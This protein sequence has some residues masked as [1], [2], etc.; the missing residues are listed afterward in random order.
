MKQLISPTI[1]ATSINMYKKKLELLNFSKVI[2]LDICDGHFVKTKTIN[3]KNCSDFDFL[4][5]DV[6]VHLMVEK[7]LDYLDDCVRLGVFK[8]FIHREIFFEIDDFIEVKNSFEKQGIEVALVLNPE[9]QV[10]NALPFIGQI[11]CVMLMSVI[12]GAEGQIFMEHVLEK[13]RQIRVLKENILIQ[14]DGGINLETGALSLERGVDILSVGSFIS[15]SKN[16]EKHYSLLQLIN[17][18]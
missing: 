10:E 16:P 12:P 6:E 14:I 18:H 8:V 5:H 4:D 17:N 7:P 15:S 1:F 2:H 9:T 3:L 11:S 13:V